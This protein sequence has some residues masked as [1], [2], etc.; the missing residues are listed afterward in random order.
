MIKEILSIE[1]TSENKWKAKYR[2]NY[3]VY[4][5]KIQFDN[6]ELKSFSC[7]CPSDYYPCKHIPKIVAAIEEQMTKKKEE[8]NEKTLTIEEL[9]K[10]V[11][12]KKL[13]EFIS[14]YAKYNVDFKNSVYLEFIKDISGKEKNNYSAVLSE[15][16]SLIGFDIEDLYYDYGH[17]ASFEIDIL[18]EMY[19]KARKLINQKL[20]DEAVLICKACI[21]EYATWLEEIDSDVYEYIDITYQEEPFN[22]IKDIINADVVDT[23]ELYEF[24]KMEMNKS[25]YK[26]HYWED[27][28]LDLLI[29]TGLKC[30]K[31][32]EVIELIDKNISQFSNKTCYEYKKMLER[33]IEILKFLNNEKEVS[34]IIEQNL[35]IPEFRKSLVQSK[36][37]AK[38]YTEAKK[39]IYDIL[40][41]HSNDN[42]STLEWKDIL[43]DIAVKEKNV[44]NMQSISYELLMKEFNSKY[45]KIFKNTFKQ[46][47]WNEYKQKLI[48]HYEKQTNGFSI[49]NNIVLNTSIANLYIEEKDTDKLIE[50]VEKK[51]SVEA[52]NKYYVHFVK[53]HPAK[54]LDLFE[55]SILEYSKN[56]GRDVYELISEMLNKILKIPG[57][58]EV[59]VKLINYLL[60]TYSNR[61][62][63]K[64]ILG[65]IKI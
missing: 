4:N 35:Q 14:L 22:I 32:Q 31:Q 57:G 29:T 1:E 18:D 5:I 27:Y 55:K 54:T 25:K 7:S 63:M 30:G 46:S 56:T 26:I 42:F 58:K 11:P 60:S 53:S 44:K 20:Y 10:N 45:F 8:A 9:L 2:G 48:L 59:V 16:L 64:E 52:I 41:N 38:Q 23:V 13:I 24:C 12:Q 50:L 62:A 37:Q 65:K 33:K 15:S 28:F 3:G 36:I 21:E 39:L 34:F 61:R 17:E 19:A 6:N 47:E 43:L 49:W 40:D 51:L